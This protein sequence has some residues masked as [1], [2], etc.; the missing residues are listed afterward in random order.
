M[1]EISFE[2]QLEAVRRE[3]EKFVETP[4]PADEAPT[5]DE[6]P[7]EEITAE[8]WARAQETLTATAKKLIQA[9]MHIRTLESELQNVRRF[10]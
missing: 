10:G 3:E 8:M 7:A 1:T 5:V 4:A 9:E 6:T 2:E